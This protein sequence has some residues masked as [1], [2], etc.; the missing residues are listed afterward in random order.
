VLLKKLAQ[1]RKAL[2]QEGEKNKRKDEEIESLRKSLVEL[3]SRL[4]VER[5]ALQQ[6]DKVLQEC[7]EHNVNLETQLSVALQ[8]LSQSPLKD[9]S[10]ILK[11]KFTSKSS[12]EFN[13]LRLENEYCDILL[14]CLPT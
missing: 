5:R 8:K 14:Y 11:N 7:I 3:E 1:F 10:A 12:I 9:S 4:D 13:K 6:K 2:A